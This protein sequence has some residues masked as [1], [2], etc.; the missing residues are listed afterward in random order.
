[1]SY[2]RLRVLLILNYST[3]LVDQITKAGILLIINKKIVRNYCRKKVTGIIKR[4]DYDF[5]S[6]FI[7]SFTI[8][9]TFFTAVSISS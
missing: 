2:K 7:S 9:S 3:V 8:S 6:S 4:S 5:L 1:M